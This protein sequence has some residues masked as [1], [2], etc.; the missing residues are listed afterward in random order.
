SRCW[1][2]RALW[3]LYGF[4]LELS[5]EIG[6]PRCFAAAAAIMLLLA[7]LPG[8]AG[9]EPEENT[10]LAHR[11]KDFLKKYCAGCHSGPDFKSEV[12]DYDVLDYN[13]L[14]K[15]RGSG[16]TEWYYVQPGLKGEA[17]LKASK[18]WKKAG[19]KERFGGRQTMPPG[20]WEEK[21]WEP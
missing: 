12:G 4:N 2:G 8:V 7:P 19:V 17:A 13:S 20:M 14:T 21:P 1:G 6:V 5:K 11:A 9:G 16:K 3:R 15:K 18:L 10:K